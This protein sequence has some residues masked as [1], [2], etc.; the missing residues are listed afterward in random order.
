M[1]YKVFDNFFFR[2]I[3][4]GMKWIDEIFISNEF[5]VKIGMSK[6]ISHGRCDVVEYKNQNIRNNENNIGY[7]KTDISD[8]YI[9]GEYITS[10]NDEELNTM[11]CDALHEM[12][13]NKM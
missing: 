7:I 6:M 8:F 11:C 9:D 13:F 10:F 12:I 5:L 3:F 4:N 2:C 1:L